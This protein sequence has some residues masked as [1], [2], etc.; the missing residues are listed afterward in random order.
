M[1]A[2]GSLWHI[3]KWRSEL[4]AQWRH[5]NLV[6]KHPPI[7]RV[8]SDLRR[9]RAALAS[10]PPGTSYVRAIGLYRAYDDTLSVACAELDITTM[11][12][13]LPDGRQRE[14]ERL[15]VEYLLGEAGLRL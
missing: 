13:E 15:R 8:S 5:V 4:P 7:E 1:S 14:L 6:P 3:H 12:T 9:L 10:L 11:L 2:I